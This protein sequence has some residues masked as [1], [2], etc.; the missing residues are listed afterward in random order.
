MS[1]LGKE[2]A[3]LAGWSDAERLCALKR[4]IPRR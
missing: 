4:I 1:R 3:A 2:A